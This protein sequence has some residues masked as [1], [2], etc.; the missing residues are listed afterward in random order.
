MKKHAKATGKSSHR[1]GHTSVQ[2][3][4]FTLLKIIVSTKNVC[5]V[6][7]RIFSSASIAREQ[8]EDFKWGEMRVTVASSKKRMGM[9]DTLITDNISS[10]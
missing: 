2:V 6:I 4:A 10:M 5:M 8:E 9:A 3:C 7:Y 1:C